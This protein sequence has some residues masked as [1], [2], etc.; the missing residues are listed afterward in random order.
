MI[1]LGVSLLIIG[2]YSFLENEKKFTA[3]YNNMLNQY[4]N[5][6]EWGHILDKNEYLEYT[7]S[8]ERHKI[9]YTKQEIYDYLL[10]LKLYNDGHT[11]VLIYY[12][13]HEWEVEYVKA[14]VDSLE[15]DRFYTIRIEQEL[16]KGQKHIYIAK[17]GE[18]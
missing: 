6:H 3:Y 11:S 2:I 16:E 8:M 1:G 9:G 15:T 17:V 13:A 10:G 18:Y 14:V 7:M 5:E 4:S 12:K